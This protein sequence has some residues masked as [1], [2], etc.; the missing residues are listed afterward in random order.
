MCLQCQLGKSRCSRDLEESE[1][2]GPI[3]VAVRPQH[4]DAAA[5]GAVAAAVRSAAL[6]SGLWCWIWR[7][8][9]EVFV[10]DR[11]RSEHRSA[12][13]WLT[14]RQFG[15]RTLQILLAIDFCHFYS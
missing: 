8:R 9:G 1:W 2:C 11:G 5:V 10:G 15:T 3:A 4:S 14:R 6:A 13:V 7:T 12:L